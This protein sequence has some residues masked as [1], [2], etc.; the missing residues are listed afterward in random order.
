MRRGPSRGSNDPV[1][2][3]DLPAPE[4]ASEDPR[5]PND[6]IQPR[7]QSGSPASVLLPVRSMIDH[8]TWLLAP[9]PPSPGSSEFG[10][11]LSGWSLPLQVKYKAR[12]S[13]IRAFLCTPS[14]ASTTGVC[15]TGPAFLFRCALRG[16]KNLVLT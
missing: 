6:W 15:L 4:E 13:V 2:L 1:L 14:P 16:R 9:L 7:F 11:D 10:F 3:P 5:R 8:E 12:P